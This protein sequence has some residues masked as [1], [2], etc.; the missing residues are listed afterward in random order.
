MVQEYRKLDAVEDSRTE[1]VSQETC[2]D[3]CKA[4]LD[5]GAFVY[6]ASRRRCFLYTE[7]GPVLYAAQK[8]LGVCEAVAAP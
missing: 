8:V 3:K 4:Q 1:G 6:Q 5:C 7:M 2:E